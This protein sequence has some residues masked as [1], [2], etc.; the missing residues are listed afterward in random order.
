MRIWASL[1]PVQDHYNI[2]IWSRTR[3][4]KLPESMKDFFFLK[5]MDTDLFNVM[6]CIN[7]ITEWY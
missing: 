2:L 6:A 7:S 3:E 4:D 1:L 5:Q